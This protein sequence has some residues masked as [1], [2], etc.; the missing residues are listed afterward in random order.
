[1]AEMVNIVVCKGGNW[2]QPGYLTHLEEALRI[3]F[4][5]SIIKARPH[6]E[7]HIKTLKRDWFIVDDMIYGVKHS[8]SGLSFNNTSNMK[9][10][11]V[12]QWCSKSFINYEICCLVFGNDCTIREDAFDV[13]DVVEELGGNN[14]S[15]SENGSDPIASKDVEVTQGNSRFQSVTS[16][17]TSNLNKRKKR[18]SDGGLADYMISATQILGFKLSKAS[19]DIS[20]TINA[21]KDMHHLVMAAMEE[22]P[23]VSKVERTMYNAKIMGRPELSIMQEFISSYLVAENVLGDMKD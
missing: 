15:N 4:P 5:T 19:N 13:V 14:E 22:V 8:S 7:S 20:A 2:F 17:V 6:I 11:D 12:K 16:G 9:Y 10:P 3:S 18:T 23:N 1:M 21:D